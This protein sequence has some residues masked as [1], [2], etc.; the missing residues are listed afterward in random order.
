M[1]MDM[2][3]E[4]T[5]E[6]A[7]D[8]LGCFLGRNPAGGLLARDDTGVP[9][10]ERKVATASVE[11]SISGLA[12]LLPVFTALLLAVPFFF[13]PEDCTGVTSGAG[14]FLPM[15]GAGVEKVFVSSEDA[16]EAGRDESSSVRRPSVVAGRVLTKSSKGMMDSPVS[17]STVTS[18]A[19]AMSKLWSLWIFLIWSRTERRR[20]NSLMQM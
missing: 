18:I 16:R 14:R 9:E 15:T 3:S 17:G 5:G 7:R 2:W 12:F 11:M 10:G 19:R 4:G 8:M 6:D 13:E 1:V 20:V